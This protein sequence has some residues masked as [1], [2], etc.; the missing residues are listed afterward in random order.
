MTA[1]RPKPLQRHG[2]EREKPAAAGVPHGRVWRLA[3]VRKVN[4][5]SVEG[6]PDPENR[7]DAGFFRQPRRTDRASLP[8]RWSRREAGSA[9]AL[10]WFRTG[11]PPALARGPAMV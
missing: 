4:T 7:V 8:A 9:P 10:S 3:A 5:A 2:F 1:D 11:R 6:C